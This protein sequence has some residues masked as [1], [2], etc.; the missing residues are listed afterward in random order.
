MNSFWYNKWRDVNVKWQ[1][2]MVVLN[3]D[4]VTIIIIIMIIVTNYG[5][6]TSM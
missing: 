4:L 1:R 2:T 3:F 5:D 6:N